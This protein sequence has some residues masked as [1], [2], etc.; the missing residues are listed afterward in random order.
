[1]SAH[2]PAPDV[3]VTDGSA[4]WRADLDKLLPIW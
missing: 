1:M 4:A 3:Q 2:S